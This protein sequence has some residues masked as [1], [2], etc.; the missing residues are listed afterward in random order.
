ML[1]LKK[2]L[3][4]G[5]FA[6]LNRI[7]DVYY[8]FITEAD[9]NSKKKIFNPNF[10]IDTQFIS[11][12]AF[13]TNH[14]GT[15]YRGGFKKDNLYFHIETYPIGCGITEFKFFQSDSKYE[16]MYLIAKESINLRKFHYQ[17]DLDDWNIFFKH[18]ELQITNNYCEYYF[19]NGNLSQ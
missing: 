19:Y 14:R 2:Q 7:K 16:A 18:G 3:S 13:A 9:K 15:F 8:F 1:P 17:L 4:P 12:E 10:K 5:D 6:L 11:I